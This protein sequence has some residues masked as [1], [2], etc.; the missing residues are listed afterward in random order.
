[1]KIIKK[2]AVAT[3]YF[4]VEYLEHDYYPVDDSVDESGMISKVLGFGLHHGLVEQEVVEEWVEKRHLPTSKKVARIDLTDGEAW[5]ILSMMAECVGKDI[6]DR[7]QL[8]Q[9]RNYLTKEFVKG[10][11]GTTE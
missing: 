5:G 3:F 10:T 9:L 4:M 1:M 2:H 7:L 8:T 11:N 6:E